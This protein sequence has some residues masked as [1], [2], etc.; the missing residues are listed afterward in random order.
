MPAFTLQVSLSYIAGKSSQSLTVVAS[1]KQASQ[2]WEHTTFQG[3]HTP[4]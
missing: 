1:R 3:A 2:V 4:G